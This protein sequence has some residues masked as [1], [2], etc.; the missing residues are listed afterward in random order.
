MFGDNEAWLIDEIIG[1]LGLAPGP[2]ACEQLRL[3][4]AL[5]LE[6]VQRQRLVGEKT[7][8][9]I[10]RKHFYDSLY[11]L[12]VTPLRP[13]KLLDL[14]TGAGLP[15][16][17]LKICLGDT[18]LYLLDANRR[19]MAF[20]KRA[21]AELGLQEVFFMAGRAEELARQEQYR[22]SFSC[23]V[24]RAVAETAVLVELA[25]PFV[26]ESGELWLYKGPQ[27]DMELERAAPAIR[28]CGGT[29]AGKHPYRLLTGE[30]RILLLVKKISPTP[31]LY[32][33]RT[34]KPARK[35]LG[36]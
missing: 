2:V 1:R 9:Q 26:R 17:P 31:N 32:P 16:L 29:P 15:G 33:R 28:T 20:L 18:P 8:E 27:G 10:I 4:A 11:L 3:F 25:L 22:E 36:K 19:K 24:S 14:G 34:G 5:L 35:P 7:A 12:A 13:G 21:C 23:V 6:G 30:K